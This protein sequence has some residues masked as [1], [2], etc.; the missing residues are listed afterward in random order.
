MVDDNSNANAGGGEGQGEGAGQGQGQAEA[1]DTTKISDANFAK[2]FEDKRLWTHPRFKEL[3]DAKT[4]LKEK[5]EAEKKAE[6][7]RLVKNQEFEK[8]AKQREDEVNRLKAEATNSRI[9]NALTIAAAKLGIGDIDAVLKLVDRSALKANDD[10]SIA[11]V[12]EAIKKLLIDKPYLKTIKNQRIGN[13]TNPQDAN[14]SG[15]KVKM[16]QLRDPVWYQKNYKNLNQ[17]L[18]NGIEDD[19][20]GVR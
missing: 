20:P 6:Q 12:D 13:G 7:D 11:G 16:S 4:K 19:R 17:L 3:G 14:E 18:K 15:Q 10:G 9:D 2:I 1:F 5:E 8:L